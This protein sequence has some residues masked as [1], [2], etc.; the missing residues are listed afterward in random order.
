MSVYFMLLIDNSQ[1]RL[2]L[3]DHNLKDTVVFF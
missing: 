3:I 2:V 1:V